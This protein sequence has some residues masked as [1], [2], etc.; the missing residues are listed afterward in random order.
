MHVIPCIRAEILLLLLLLLPSLICSKKNRTHLN[1][2]S[3]TELVGTD[4][5]TL[6]VRLCFLPIYSGHQV[7]WA[8]SWLGCEDKNLFLFVTVRTVVQ[9]LD[10][11]RSSCNSSTN[12]CLHGIDARKVLYGR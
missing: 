12:T 2:L 4:F 5:E 9:S 10:S 1:L 3:I 11:F 6:I 8:F 7:R